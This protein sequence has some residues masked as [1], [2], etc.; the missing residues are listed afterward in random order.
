MEQDESRDSF[1]PDDV[2]TSTDSE[3]DDPGDVQELHEKSRRTAQNELF[4]AL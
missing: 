2:G 1:S 3:V 4:K